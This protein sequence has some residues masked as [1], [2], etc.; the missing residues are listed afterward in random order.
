MF[1]AIGRVNGQDQFSW[2]LLVWD[3]WEKIGTVWSDTSLDQWEKHKA[4]CCLGLLAVRW[5]CMELHTLR[6]FYYIS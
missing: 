5:H 4:I 2:Q 1:W 6:T 3:E